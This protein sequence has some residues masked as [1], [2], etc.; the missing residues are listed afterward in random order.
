MKFLR[1]IF[2]SVWGLPF[3]LALLVV[4][5]IVASRWHARFDLTS[6][7]RFTLSDS[8]VS[9]LQKLNNPVEI[10]VLLKGNYPSGFKK[11]ASSTEDI[12]RT[13]KELAGNKLQYRFVAP[14]EKIGSSDVSYADTALALGAQSI[15]LT[16]QLKDGQQQQF[17]YPVA[18]ISSN[19]KM[20]VTQLY[21][22]KT[23]LVTNEAFTDA[24]VLLE[25]QLANAIFHL[26]QPQKPIIGYAIGNGEPMDLTIYDLAE[27]TLQKEYELQ[28]I[29]VAAQPFINPLCELLVIVKPTQSFTAD[30]K[31]KID[32]YIMQGGKVMFFLDRLNAEMDSLQIKNEVIAYDREL[33]LNDLLF[34]YGARINGNLLMDLQCDYLPFDI[35]GNGQF[36]FLPWNYFPVLESSENHPINK[37]LGFVCG[38]FVNTIDTVEAEGISKTILLYSSV[39]ARTISTPALISGKENVAAPVDDQYRFQHLPAAVLLEGKFRS[40]FANRLTNA[41]KDSLDAVGMPFSTQAFKSSKVLVVADG[42]VVLNPVIKGNQPLGMGMNPFTAGTEREFPF[43]NRD[44]ILNAIEYMVYDNGLSAAK[45]KDVKVYLM[46][47]KKVRAEKSFWMLINV[48]TPIVGILLFAIVFQWIR[49]RK[50]IK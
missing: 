20:V 12:L 8:T 41:M 47:A 48:L 38:K 2:N 43:A 45:A 13:F 42:D 9:L 5:N 31:L 36:D 29:N 33:N 30:Q 10:T 50:Y 18:L 46:D 44:F 32:Q 21:K 4:A 7:K 27:N 37:G 14:D 49:K 16:S 15:N 11:M 28:L 26:N 1:S 23:P 39:N 25:Y 24:E 35:S 22:G 34:R 17:V 6:E 40:L 19:G 3:L